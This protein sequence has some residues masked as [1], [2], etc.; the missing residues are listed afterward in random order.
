MQC[1]VCENRPVYLGSSVRNCKTRINEHFYDVR[2]C[3]KLSKNKDSFANHMKRHYQSLEEASMAKL[4]EDVDVGIRTNLRRIT[5]AGTKNC[6]LCSAERFDILRGFFTGENLINL[7]DEVY[8][9]CRHRQSF[10]KWVLKNDSFT[11]D[12]MNGENTR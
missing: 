12:P 3:I 10:P 2:S 4:R 1:N 9:K 6:E 5:K 11:D 7:R 8:A